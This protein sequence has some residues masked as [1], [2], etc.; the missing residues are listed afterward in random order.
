MNETPN[1]AAILI[2]IFAAVG[3]VAMILILWLGM[4]EGT[5]DTASP[6]RRA[7]RQHKRT[8]IERETGIEQS[9]GAGSTIG[10]QRDRSGSRSGGQREG[11]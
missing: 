1:G 5:R 10:A 7:A 4:R 3:L 6:G 8:E 9:R 2:P 11:A